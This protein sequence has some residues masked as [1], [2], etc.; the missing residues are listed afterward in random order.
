[1]KFHNS[2]MKGEPKLKQLPHTKEILLRDP[3]VWIIM[4]QAAKYVTY[5]FKI[6]MEKLEVIISKFTTLFL[7]LIFKGNIR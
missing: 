5:H 1:M 7:Y 6:F 4:V 3:N 2:E